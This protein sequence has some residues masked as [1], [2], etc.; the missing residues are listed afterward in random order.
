MYFHIQ[1]AYYRASDAQ[2]MQ[3]NKILRVRI[4]RNNTVSQNIKI[5]ELSDIGH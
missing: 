2:D 5:L 4:S 3:G 1:T